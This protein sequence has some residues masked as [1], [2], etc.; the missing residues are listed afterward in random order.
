LTCL[1]EQS[2]QTAVREERNR[3]ACEIH[4][5][6]AQHF[7]GILLQIGLAQRLVRQQPEEAWRLVV[8][9]GVLARSAVEEARQSV[10]ALQPD[11]PFFSNLASSL[12][13]TIAQMTAETSVSGEV[14]IY[15]TPRLLPPDVGM[16]LLR[17]GQEAVKNAIRHARA[18]HIFVELAFE[19]THV[20]LCVQDD[21]LGFDPQS[22]EES[23]GFGLTAMRQRAQRFHGSLTINSQPGQGTEIV[24]TVT[25][26]GRPPET[27]AME[28]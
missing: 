24:V 4:D 10:W 7:A 8:Q 9:A 5:A 25:T 13:V 11:A 2:R 28:L 17:I 6:L 3:L 18:Q 16:N 27:G 23:G 26:E 12:P 19:T 15:G 22:Q 21:G 20:R 1:A 14:K